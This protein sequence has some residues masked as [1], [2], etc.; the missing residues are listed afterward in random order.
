MLYLVNEI[1]TLFV[2]AMES[3]RSFTL[4]IGS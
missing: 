3:Q 4:A 2:H 1:I